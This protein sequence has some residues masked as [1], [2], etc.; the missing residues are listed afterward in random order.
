V[1]ILGAITMNNLMV[2]VTDFPDVVINDEVVLYGKQG[3]NS[4]WG[5]EIQKYI[6]ES[7]VEMTTRWSINPKF[8]TSARSAT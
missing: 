7:M 8:L 5:A 1:P 2:D 6:K 3:S 4:I